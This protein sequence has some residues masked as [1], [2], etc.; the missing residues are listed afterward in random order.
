ML[1][2]HGFRFPAVLGLFL[3]VL[4][5]T[6][7]G[8]EGMG[9]WI[10]RA[11]TPIVRNEAVGALVGDK[12]YLAGGFSSAGGGA[13]ELQIYS[14][15]TN[16]WTVGA[17]MPV[18]MHHPNVAASGGKL[19]VLGGCDHQRKSGATPNNAPWLGSHHA[20]EYD[21]S[22]DKWRIL[23]PLPHSSAAGALVPFGGKLYLIG[24]VDTNGVV[25]DLVQEY[26]PVA[27]TWR[28]RAR[29]PLAREHIGAAALD[30]LIYVVAGR[31]DG[32][33]GVSVTVLQA[34]DPVRNQ[35]QSLPNLPTSRSGLCLAAAKGRLYAMGGEW[36]G[37]FDTNEEYDP[38]RK[39]WRTVAKMTA[40]RHGF[41]AVT[42]KDTV[43][44]MGMVQ[45]SEAFLPPGPSSSL[46][47]DG[48]AGD[49][50]RP[51][52]RPG[53]EAL[54]DGCDALGRPRPARR[55]MPSYGWT[56]AFPSRE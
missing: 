11:G 32:L 52:Y 9:Q 40:K 51:G 7:S 42:Y 19:Y 50:P 5:G 20:F 15:T 34:Y 53:L 12:I 56:R 30:S 4:A 22:A 26:D 29:M 14:P 38:A 41:A 27:E 31:Q 43:F 45:A 35:W 33:S 24:G 6:A 13:S 25:L 23:K 36:P 17:K 2:R 16:S 37:V 54:P 1:T 8:Q 3:L 48:K 47:R 28:E 18:G 49:L 21:P 39:T 46:R 55:W 10:P 44:V